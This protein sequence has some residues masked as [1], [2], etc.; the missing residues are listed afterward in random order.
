M[1]KSLHPAQ[2]AKWQA[3]PYQLQCVHIWHKHSYPQAVSFRNL[4]TFRDTVTMLSRS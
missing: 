1:R 3:T 4:G 2:L